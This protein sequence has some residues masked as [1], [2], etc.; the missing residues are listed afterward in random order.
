MVLCIKVDSFVVR[1]SRQYKAAFPESFPPW[2]GALS[3]VNCNGS[4]WPLQKEAVSTHRCY[5]GSTMVGR[6]FRH[7]ERST[8]QPFQKEAVSTGK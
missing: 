6:C 4:K 7:V 3:P 8:K 1:E 2:A 5:L